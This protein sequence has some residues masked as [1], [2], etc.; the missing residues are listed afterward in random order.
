MTAGTARRPDRI[1]VRNAAFQQWL[2]LL[3]NRSQRHRSGS[4]LAHGVR[5]ITIAADRGLPFHAILSDGR[6]SPSEWAS[7]LWT[8]LDT[9]HVVLTPELMRELGDKDDGVPELIGVLAI[10]P[11]DLGRLDVADRPF[12]VVFDRPSGPGNIG[13][14]ARSVDAFGGAGLVVTGHAA[15]PYDPKS[16]RA[17]TGSLL[18][19]DVVR[20][21]SH[22]EVLAWAAASGADFAVLGLDEAGDADP[23]SID[24]RGPTIAVI[25]N[26]TRGLT[27]AWRDSCDPLVRIPMQGR[28]SSLNAATAGSIVL[29]EA[30]LQ[31]SQRRPA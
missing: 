12:I 29:Y 24:L 16:V 31:R 23:R 4:F 18:A 17:S 3:T 14:L 10:P 27:A 13:T 22:R 19:V 26:E 25:G 11:D 30:M 1:T 2:S 20:V 8:S 15:D 21:P 9:R 28:A 5:A 7:D 6:A